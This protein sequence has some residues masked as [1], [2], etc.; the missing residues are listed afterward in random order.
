MHH[1]GTRTRRQTGLRT[2]SLWTS[3]RR[4][5]VAFTVVS[6][7]MSAIRRNHASSA[8]KLQRFRKPYTPERAYR[9]SVVPLAFYCLF[10]GMFMLVFA[11]LAGTSKNVHI[12]EFPFI[13]TMPGKRFLFAGIGAY[14]LPI[15]IGLIY[16]RQWALWGFI[17]Y[18]TLCTVYVLVAWAAGEVPRG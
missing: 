11:A 8:V 13:S 1:N 16:R 2:F 7:C 4:G 18:I 10:G 14:F 9:V 3:N 5:L 12:G 15:G 17:A 6:Q